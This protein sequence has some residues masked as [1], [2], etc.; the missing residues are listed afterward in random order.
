MDE[1]VHHNREFFVYLYTKIISYLYYILFYNIDKFY[2]FGKMNSELLSNF[3]PFWQEAVEMTEK[4]LKKMKRYQLL[5]L[6]I[7][8][9]EETEELKQKLEQAE[10]KQKAQELRIS[11]LGSLAEAALEINGVFTA[12]Q[13]AADQYLAAAQKQADQLVAEATRQAEEILKRAENK[14]ECESILNEQLNQR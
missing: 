3:A 2:R 9:T 12:A 1:S 4:E 5:E 13:Q 10:A 14:L 8:Q 6:L 7:M 11:Q